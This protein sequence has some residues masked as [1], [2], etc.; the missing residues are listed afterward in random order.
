M[1]VGV[2][3]ASHRATE[4]RAEAAASGQHCTATWNPGV[5]A[6][7]VPAWLVLGAPQRCP[8]RNTGG[9]QITY[10]SLLSIK[11]SVSFVHLRFCMKLIA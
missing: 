6:L 9:L 7:P 2:A 10:I 4:G 8:L 3:A 1:P 5:E 11:F